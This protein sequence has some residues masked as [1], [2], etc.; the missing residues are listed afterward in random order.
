MTYFFL[1]TYE[2]LSKI[3]N[4]IYV[5]TYMCV[6]MCVCVTIVR[7]ELFNRYLRHTTYTI[8]VS[9]LYLRTLDFGIFGLFFRFTEEIYI[10]LLC[11][12]SKRHKCIMHKRMKYFVNSLMVLTSRR[13]TL[14]VV[15]FRQSFSH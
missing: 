9:G 13:A 12:I 11:F 5:Y 6:C 7:Y 1:Y 2:T 10:Y 15:L 14:E 3:V 8:L 4:I